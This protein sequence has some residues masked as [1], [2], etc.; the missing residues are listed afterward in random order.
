MVFQIENLYLDEAAKVANAAKHILIEKRGNIV[1]YNVEV[2]PLRFL[3]SI[4]QTSV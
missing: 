2:R 3:I 4:K 1:E